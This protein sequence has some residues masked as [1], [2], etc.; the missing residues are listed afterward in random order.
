MNLIALKHLPFDHARFDL[1][2]ALTTPHYRPIYRWIE[3]NIAWQNFYVRSAGEKK[4]LLSRVLFGARIHIGTGGRVGRIWQT[5]WM[6]LTRAD[7][8]SR[9]TGRRFVQSRPNGTLLPLHAKVLSHAW[10]RVQI[11]AGCLLKNR[12]HPGGSTK[13]CN[14]LVPRLFRASTGFQKIFFLTLSAKGKL[15]NFWDRLLRLN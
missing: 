4:I 2:A 6:D 15:N 13:L 8:L 10:T 11:P 14:P 1:P 7:G 9:L 5:G 3:N 12:T